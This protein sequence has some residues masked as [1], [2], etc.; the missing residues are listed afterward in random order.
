MGVP[1]EEVVLSGLPIDSKSATPP[2]DV[3]GNGPASS[4][5]MQDRSHSVNQALTDSGFA[6]VAP[7]VTETVLDLTLTIIGLD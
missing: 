7:A 5:S 2:T 4:Q 1:L 6:V 3:S